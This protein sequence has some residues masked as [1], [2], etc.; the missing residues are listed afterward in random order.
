MKKWNKISVMFFFIPA[1][2][3]LL[4]CEE[5]DSKKEWGF[6][7]VYMP[8]AAL[9]NGGITNNYPVPLSKD[10]TPNYALDE[11]N[12]LLHIY[13]GVYRSG[14]Q[15]LESFTVQI[16]GDMAAATVAAGNIS[17]GVVLPQDYYTIPNQITVANGEREAIFSMTVDL[18]RLETD[19][20][21]FGGKKIIA[22]AGISNPSKYEL[23]ESLSQT[24]IVIDGA[25]FLPPPPEP[26]PVYG[27][28]LIDGGDFEGYD[29]AQKWSIVNQL[30]NAALT[31]IENGQLKIT[32][33]TPVR[34]GAA[35]YQ[36]VPLESGKQ[37]EF[38]AD[39]SLSGQS[40]SGGTFQFLTLISTAEPPAGGNISSLATY[41]AKDNFYAWMGSFANSG[42]GNIYRTT[43]GG[44]LPGIEGMHTNMGTGIFTAPPS[45]TPG[46]VYIIFAFFSSDANGNAGTILID[47]ISIRE[48]I[49]D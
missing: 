32:C 25:F 41:S 14:L 7:R 49:P 30:G 22:V 28:E 36:A 48:I 1:L 43:T 10:A 3:L 21:E 42:A 8:Q 17:K 26:E 27:P 20:P 24:T 33:S 35:V 39:M 46:P 38:T 19:Y 2:S 40:E 34:C 9:D 16:S 12:K 44:T 5:D 15:A 23:N 4:S 37:Y 45:Y 6:A 47:N 13:L 11:E 29:L 18:G 31:L